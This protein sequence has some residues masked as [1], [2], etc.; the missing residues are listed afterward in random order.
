MPWIDTD[1]Y[2]ETDSCPICHELY[3]TTQAIYETPC[4]HKF[5]NNCLNDFCEYNK[6]NIVCPVC[7]GNVGNT[8][9]DVYAFMAKNLGNA[10]GAPL[11]HGNENITQIYNKQPETTGG[12]RYKKK[13]T[14]K[15]RTKIRRIRRKR[16]TRKLNKNSR[17]NCG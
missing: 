15:T 2:D 7:R 12:K 11:F 14:K 1:K 6:G 4:H 5:H 3:G 13:Q 16:R 9:M 10:S 8:C 17:K